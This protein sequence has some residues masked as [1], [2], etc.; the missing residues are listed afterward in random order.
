MTINFELLKTICETPGAPGYETRIRALVIAEAEKLVDELK[1]DHLGNVLAL[2]KG[3][4]NP[5]GKKVMLAAHMDEISFMVTHVDEQGFLRFHPLGGFDPKTLT[6]MRVWVHGQQDLPGVMGSKPVHIMSPEERKRMPEIKDY[7]IDLGLPVEEVKKL[8]P[9]GSTVTRR[10]E[11]APLGHLVSG[12]SLDNRLSVFI[13]LEMLRNL[14]TVPYDTWAVFTV[15]EE[16]GLRGAQVAAHQINPDFGLAIDVT[17]ANDTPGVPGQE[18]VTEIGKGAA[19]KMYDS[20]TICD[21]RM[22]N[23]LKQTAEKNNIKWQPEILTAGGTDTA[24]IQRMGK[25]GAIAGA[26]S[27]PLRYVHQVIETAH[28][29]DVQACTN[30]LVAAMSAIDQY[31][32]SFWQV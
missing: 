26:V 8:V 32:W 7:Y 30:L 6:S 1:V 9:A 15:Q 23:F 18:K 10:Q 14:D 31:D 11:L 24:G 20:S 17:I 16:V 22:V 13:L 25:N 28:P 29:E 3:S 21:Y 12:K 19:I 27:I 5:E 2:K 4:A